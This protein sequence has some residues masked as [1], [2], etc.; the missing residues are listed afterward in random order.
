MKRIALLGYPLSHSLSPIMQQAA[1]RRAGL[2]WRYEALPTPP[3]ALEDRMASMREGRWHGANVT[4]PLKERVI[5]LLDGLDHEAAQVGA[6]NTIVNE[7]GRWLGYNTDVPGFISDL[8]T[9]WGSSGRGAALILGAGGAARAAAFGLARLQLELRLVA[10]NLQRGRALASDLER[11]TGVEISVYPWRPRSFET[12]GEGCI[13]LVNATPIGMVPSQEASPWPEEVPLPAKA[14]IYDL[15]Y[16][17]RD[18][19]L[20]QS[21]RL[22]GLRAAGGAGMLLEQGALAFELWTGL[23]APREPMR[24]ALQLALEHEHA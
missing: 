10:R 23:P 15:V 11:S 4:L 7:Q 17:P 21:A 2:D 6:V 5:P 14:F 20:V 1:F 12:L 24:A 8:N 9:C 18:T 16:R 13:L 19:P 22:A 3:D